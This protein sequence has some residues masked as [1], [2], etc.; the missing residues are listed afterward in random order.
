MA[1]VVFKFF[2]WLIT[3][4]RIILF[5]LLLGLV[6][7]YSRWWKGG[8]RFLVL[9]LSLLMV[10]AV[11]PTGSMLLSFLEQRFPQPTEI[12]SD[13]KGIIL[14]GGSFDL[15][16]TADLKR[17][18]YNMAGGR[19]M[20]FMQL[21]AKYPQLPI[22]F[23][24]GGTNPDPD[25]NEA[26]NM[27]KILLGFGFDVSRVTFEDKSKST[28]ENAA[29]SYAMIKPKPEDKWLLVTSAYHMP[30]SVGLFRTAGWNVIPFPVDYH[31]PKD[32]SWLDLNWDLS[33]GL[34]S[35]SNG[36]R[37]IGGMS[38]NYLSGKS[39]VWMASP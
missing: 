6:M 33:K 39:N 8:R 27:K 4:D 29:F 19:I 38:A 11:V 13:V 2:G 34:M 14:L 16:V 23:T 10:T 30:R 1:E 3:I 5:L 26:Y 21:A 37:E 32:V 17:H 24:G 28:V 31:S 35:W 12:P 25:A 36:I 18:S 15:K 9:A 22:V 7:L 20:D